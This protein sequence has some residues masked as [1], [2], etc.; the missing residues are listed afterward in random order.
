MLIPGYQRHH[1]AGV[2][3]RACGADGLGGLLG[4]LVAGLGVEQL[5]VVLAACGA[6]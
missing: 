5:Q 3:D 4:G 2:F 1:Q 6:V